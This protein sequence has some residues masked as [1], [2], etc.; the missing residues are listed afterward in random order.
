MST[1]HNYCAICNQTAQPETSIDC[2]ACSQLFH[3][4]CENIDPARISQTEEEQYSCR[5]CSIMD[6]DVVNISTRS[7]NSIIDT[8]E[9][10]P[11]LL[12][13]EQSVTE[14]YS[15]IGHIVKNMPEYTSKDSPTRTQITKE[16]TRNSN[17]EVPDMVENE[18]NGFIQTAKPNGSAQ[19]E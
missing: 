16:E 10:I 11:K 7:N 19:Q 13:D 14:D 6:M 9:T 8:E 15:E 4:A 1:I 18:K 17:T 5:S 3:Y 12:L 2:I